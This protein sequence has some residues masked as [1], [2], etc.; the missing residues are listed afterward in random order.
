[1]KAYQPISCDFHDIL[2]DAAVRRL[3]VEVVWKSENGGMQTSCSQI[4]DITVEGKEEFLI[5]ESDEKLR[6]DQLISVNHQ[7]RAD[8]EPA[9]MQ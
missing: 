1:M 7:Q 4:K 3:L 8:Y 5:L 9:A 6:L 2:E